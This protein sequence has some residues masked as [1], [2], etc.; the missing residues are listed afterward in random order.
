MNFYYYL[1]YLN[2]R[3]VS[4]ELDV[5]EMITRLAWKYGMQDSI[6]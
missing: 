2:T 5:T 1:T 4:L 3:D 6:R